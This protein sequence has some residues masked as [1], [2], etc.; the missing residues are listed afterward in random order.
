[1]WLLQ[2][3]VCTEIGVGQLSRKHFVESFLWIQFFGCCSRYEI[4]YHPEGQ[5]KVPFNTCRL[6]SVTAPPLEA[7]CQSSSPGPGIPSP[8]LGLLYAENRLPK[9]SGGPD[10]AAQCTELNRPGLESQQHHLLAVCPQAR[11]LESWIT[12]C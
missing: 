3:T 2:L 6:Q 5:D 1:M 7:Q 9:P 8:S 4:Y 10:F 12:R 11:Y